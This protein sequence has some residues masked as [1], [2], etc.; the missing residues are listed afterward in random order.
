MAETDHTRLLETALEAAVRLAKA[1]G[2]SQAC[3][4][5]FC[6]KCYV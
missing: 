2:H 6:E 4:F 5:K 3:G 1:K